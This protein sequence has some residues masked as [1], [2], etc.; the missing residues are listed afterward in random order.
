MRYENENTIGV[1]YFKFS[2]KNDTVCF[3][4]LWFTLWA[5]PS[6]QATFWVSL[7]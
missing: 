7:M 2:I 4:S 1:L 5:I 3:T 6:L